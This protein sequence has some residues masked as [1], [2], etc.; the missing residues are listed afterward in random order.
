MVTYRYQARVAA[1]EGQRSK[2]RNLCP[3]Q[4]ISCL[5]RVKSKPSVSAE[6]FLGCF[7]TAEHILPY[8]SQE[9]PLCLYVQNILWRACFFWCVY[10]AEHILPY[11]S[12]EQ[13]L[14]LQM[15]SAEKKIP[16]FDQSVWTRMC[17]ELS[18]YN[19]N[20]CVW[21]QKS[22]FC[23]FCNELSVAFRRIRYEN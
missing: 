21:P 3:L 23:L 14:C 6:Y 15:C 1:D 13:T 19:A 10:S 8:K 18:T 12:Q 20:T 11:K 4:S 16:S 7:S 17:P 22:I 9:Q 2:Q 5:A